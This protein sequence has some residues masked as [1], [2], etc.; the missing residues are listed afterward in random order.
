MDEHIEDLFANS[1]VIDGLMSYY[2]LEDPECLEGD[3]VHYPVDDFSE[4][5]PLTGIDCGSIT[6]SKTVQ[7]LEERAAYVSARPSAMVIKKGADIE[8]ARAEGRFGILFYSQKHY[9][10][11]GGVDALKEYY[12]KGLRIFQ[13]AYNARIDPE[14]TTE[15]E[16]LAGGSDQPDQGLT[17]L[18]RRVV[19]ELNRLNMLVDVS[20]L[21]KPSVM[22]TVEIS[23]A[24]VLANHANAHVLTD[25]PRNKSDE[26]L[27]AIA[28]TGGV[29]GLT[30]VKWM[31]DRNGDGQAGI[32]DFIAHMD[33]IVDR[34]GIDHV[35]IA[36]DSSLNG[37]WKSSRHYA[38]ESLGALDRWKRV[39]AR[40][41]AI[42]D[43][44]GRRKYSDEDLQK[45]LGLNFLRVYKQVLI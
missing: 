45:I 24:P 32:D 17:D 28:G 12:Q 11:Q 37:W 5:K 16:M 14:N 31:L 9:P 1:L 40:L 39:A 27:L 10:L 13:L 43:D 34:V 23:T 41:A 38:D 7:L 35:G 26:E 22:E 15:A 29:I 18:G 3:C 30:L 20:H 6:V 21:S 8:R 33:Y 19:A 4:L 36:S 44:R 2:F 25:S 42:T